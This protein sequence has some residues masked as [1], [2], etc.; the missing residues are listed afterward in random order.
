MDEKFTITNVMPTGNDSP[1]YGTEYYVKFAESEQTFQLW[2]KTKPEEKQELEGHIEGNKFVK[3]KKAFNDKPVPAFTPASKGYKDNSDGQRQGMCINNAAN[4]V[5]ANAPKTI[6][7][8]DWAK[9]VHTYA[10]ALYNLGDLGKVEA[11]ALEE[12]PATVQ[13]VFGVTKPEK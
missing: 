9:M 4:F 3:A 1:K 11:V 7:A 6:E 8:A 12:A 5:N 2:F 13:D 10:N